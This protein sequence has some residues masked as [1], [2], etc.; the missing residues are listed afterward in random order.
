MKKIIS[1]AKLAVLAL[2]FLAPPL[3]AETFK[4]TSHNLNHY[5]IDAEENVH[6]YGTESLS[7]FFHAEDLNFNA[8]IETGEILGIGISSYRFEEVYYFSY[9][10][11]GMVLDVRG[12]KTHLTNEGFFYSTEGYLERYLAGPASYITVVSTVPEP[13]SLLLMLSGVLGIAGIA[14]CR[15]KPT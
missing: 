8:R 11:S 4:F 13:A 15:R 2:Y 12:I 7:G 3:C 5:S 1:I 10:Q 9:D 14:T 6:N